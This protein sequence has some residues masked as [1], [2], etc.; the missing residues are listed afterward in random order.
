MTDK[1]F[2]Y[3][4]PLKCKSEVMS[5]EKQFI[6]ESGVP[7]AIVCDMSMEQTSPAIK[8]FLN[9]IGTTVRVVKERTP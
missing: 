6:K 1:G 7:D 4:V 3:V 9:N 5:M 2:L 8:S